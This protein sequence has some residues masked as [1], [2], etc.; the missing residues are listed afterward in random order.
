MPGL[1]APSCRSTYKLMVKV[2]LL[3][4]AADTGVA[5]LLIATS[6]VRCKR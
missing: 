3:P 1:I 2:K 6:A 5:V 4:K